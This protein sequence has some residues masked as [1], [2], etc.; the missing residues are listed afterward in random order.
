M[1]N[2]GA[3]SGFH[4]KTRY[5]TLTVT[6]DDTARTGAGWLLVHIGAAPTQHP[7]KYVLHRVVQVHGMLQTRET[8]KLPLGIRFQVQVIVVALVTG[9]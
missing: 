9:R 5:E 4:R 7:A 2:Q 6:S 3:P 1:T 8:S